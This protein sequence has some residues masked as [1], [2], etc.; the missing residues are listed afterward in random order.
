MVRW[1]GRQAVD[2]GWRIR[3]PAHPRALL[4]IG[5][6]IPMHPMSRSRPMSPKSFLRTLAMG[7]AVPRLMDRKACIE[8]WSAQAPCWLSTST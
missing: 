6:T 2:S 4:T 7:T 1:T 8:L 5:T 3:R